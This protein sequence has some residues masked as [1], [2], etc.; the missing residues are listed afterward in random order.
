MQVCIIITSAH[1]H[2]KR[3][4]A[5]RRTWLKR[6]PS[7]MTATFIVG[8]GPSNDEP[9]VLQVAA[10]DDYGSLWVKVREAFRYSLR[11]DQPDYD[12]LFKCDDDTYVVPERIESAITEVKPGRLGQYI[13]RLCGHNSDYCQGGAGYLLSRWLVG[14][15]ATAPDCP[16]PLWGEDG[17]VGCHA[18]S[19]VRALPCF[20]FNADANKWPTP[21]ND[22]ISAHRVRTIEHMLDLHARYLCVAPAVPNV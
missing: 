8:D 11:F 21:T 19:L 7:N 18:R 20:R 4:E 5:V 15:L 2:A 10:P 12:Y 1:C 3:R 16:D 9:D 6:L 13:G 14:K 17:W 22:L